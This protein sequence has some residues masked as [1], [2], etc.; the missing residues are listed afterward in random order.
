M[1]ALI[2]RVDFAKVEVDGETVGEIG[3]GLLVLL[4]AAEDDTETGR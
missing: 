1:K 3:K 4:G 2:Q